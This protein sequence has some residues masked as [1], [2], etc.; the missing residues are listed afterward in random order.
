MDILVLDIGIVSLIP[1]AYSVYN[2]IVPRAFMFLNCCIYY[3]LGRLFLG[4]PLRLLI[5]IMVH[6]PA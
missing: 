5:F 6:N 4:S 2:H 3:D 1:A